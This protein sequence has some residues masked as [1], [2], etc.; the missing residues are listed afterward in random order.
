MSDCVFCRIVR[1]ESPAHVV[2]EDDHVLAIMDIGQVNP[3]HVL[4]LSKP[5]VETMLDAEEDLAAH[6]FRIANRIAKAA[7]HALPSDGLTILQA[8]RPAGFQTVPH[9]HLHILPRFEADGVDLVWPAKNP[10]QDV[11]AS[12]AATLRKTLTR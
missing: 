1:G 9:L 2:H 4:I 12:Y 11:L 8:N 3:G 7:Q 5:H 10:P 6:L